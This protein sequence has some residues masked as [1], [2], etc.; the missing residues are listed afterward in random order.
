MSGRLAVLFSLLLACGALIAGCGDDSGGGGGGGGEASSGQTEGAKVID[1]ASMEDAKG[2]VKFCQGKDTTGAVAALEKNF[3]KKFADQGLKMEFVEFP[4]SADEQRNQFIQRQ[5]AKSGDCDLFGSDV[6]WTAEFAQQKWLYDV[7]PYM[8]KRRSEFLPAPLETV[9]YDGKLWGAPLNT[10]ASFIYYRDDKTD[11]VPAT[12]QELYSKAAEGDGMVFQGA[13]YEGLTCNWLELA[14]AAGGSVLSE[15]GEEAT[16]DSP[17]NVKATQLMMDVIK[18]GGAP[19]A[20]T[21]Y[22]EPESLSAFQTGKYTFMR[23][24]PYAYALNEKADKVKGKFKVAPLPEFEGAGKAQILG[25]ADLVISAVRREPRRS[26]GFARLHVRPGAPE[27]DR[28]QV[29]PRPDPRRD[30]RRARRSRRRCPSRRRAQGGGLAGQGASGLAGVPADLAGDLQ[31]RQPGARGPAVR[32]GRDE[33]GAGGHREGPADVL[34]SAAGSRRWLIRHGRTARAARRGRERLSTQRCGE[35]R[36]P[37]RPCARPAQDAAATTSPSSAR[38]AVS[39]RSKAS[40][41]CGWRSAN[42]LPS[43][44]PLT[45]SRSRWNV[46]QYEPSAGASCGARSGLKSAGRAAPARPSVSGSP[47]STKTGT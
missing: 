44:S 12:W 9:D 42:A 16:I 37:A 14:F 17:E 43:A 25:G 13:A 39:S 33:A 18:D 27:A 47:A 46:H 36:E 19:K 34:G 2:T 3:N 23:N 15:D 1:P 26:A 11:S 32:R 4:A 30:L 31:E 35:R 6:I 24:W 21:T 5:Q 7:T 41:T 10:D 29:Q 8:E 22:M 28:E 38:H 40:R 20:V 45:A